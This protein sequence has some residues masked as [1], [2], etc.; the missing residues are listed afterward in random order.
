MDCSP[1]GSSVH[2]IL[3]ARILEWIATSSS[4]DLPKPGVKPASLRSLTSPAL[5]GRLFTTST[6]QFTYCHIQ[7]P[8]GNLQLSQK[9]LLKYLTLQGGNFPS[10]YIT[11]CPSIP[12]PEFLFSAGFFVPTPNMDIMLAV[13]R[14]CLHNRTY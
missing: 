12:F 8:I 1:S 5:A 3:Q 6:T 7:L 10:K 13:Y 4:R 2:G 9:H 14:L 11:L